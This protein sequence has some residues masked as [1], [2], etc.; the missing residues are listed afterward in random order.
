M[1]IVFHKNF[2]KRYLKLSKPLKLKIK[3][4]N[5]LFAQD[6]YHP[7]LNNH[8]LNGKYLGYRSINVTGDLRIIY[9]LLNNEV[10]L[11]SEIGSHALLYR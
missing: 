8:P 9:K 2:E 6:P 4:N 11:F 10:V 1:K 5:I 7:T 3:E